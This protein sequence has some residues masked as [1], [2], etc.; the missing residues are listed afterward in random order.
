MLHIMSL[1]LPRRQKNSLYALFAIAFLVVG[2]GT[3]RTILVNVV[4]N[5]DYDVSLLPSLV[6]IAS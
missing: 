6:R 3:A 4:I 1:H 5:K 2:A